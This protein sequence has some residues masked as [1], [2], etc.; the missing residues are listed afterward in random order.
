MKLHVSEGRK[1]PKSDFVSIRPP[2]SKLKNVVNVTIPDDAGDEASVSDASEQSSSTAS[3]A[4][5]PTIKRRPPPRR[6]RPPPHR[7]RSNHMHEDLSL[8]E[9]V[10][11]LKQR[12][13]LDPPKQEE[14]EERSEIDVSVE[15]EESSVDG[16]ISQDDDVSIS[17]YESEH[18]PSKRAPEVPKMSREEL[19]SKLKDAERFGVT[20]Q[21]DRSASHRELE[22]EYERVQKQ[23]QTD[24]Q[25]KFARRM[26]MMC[27]S[28]LEFLNTT[29]DPA[30]LSLEGWS[31][32]V[33]SSVDDYD[34]IL[35]RLVQKWDDRVNVAPE[36]E[37]ILTL[38][39]SAFM[40]HL[41]SS[42]FK[43]APSVGEVAK[44][45]P[46]LMR[47]IAKAMAKTMSVPQ[48]TPQIPPLPMDRPLP[49]APSENQRREHARDIPVMSSPPID[50]LSKIMP[51]MSES[52]VDMLFTQSLMNTFQP[53]ATAAKSDDDNTRIVEIP[54][55][56]TK[57]A[58]KTLPTVVTKEDT[59]KTAISLDDD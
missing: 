2:H 46:D 34:G 53:S 21:T 44:D 29:Y 57:K 38:G 4:P 49:P 45:N 39:G 55:T 26:L 42:M 32:Q 19:W 14:E 48:N 7:Q 10:N 25:V 15:E 58:S 51:S 52:P 1:N 22:Y 33:M 30:G 13:V 50:I 11:P 43:N 18:T 37:L 56:N 31:D 23:V 47:E 59:T 28:G 17:V 8:L 54:A 16:Y 12:P 27:V 40:F 20:S 36:V 9:I 41:T 24:R 3:V 6:R 35:E 5:E